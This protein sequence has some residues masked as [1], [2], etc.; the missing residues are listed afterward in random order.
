MDLILI[1]IVLLSARK[2]FRLF[3]LQLPWRDLELGYS[4]GDSNCLSAAGSWGIWMRKF[5]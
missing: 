4:A 2:R 5:P 1:I 3:A